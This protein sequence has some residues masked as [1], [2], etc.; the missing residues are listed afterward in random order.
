MAT[1]GIQVLL[2]DADL[3][4]PKQHEI[5]GLENEVGLSTLLI[6]NPDNKTRSESD[7]EKQVLTKLNQCIQLTSIPK[8][9]VITSGFVPSNPTEVLRSSLMK[10]WIDA[11]RAS[12]DIDVIIIDTPPLLLF[13]DSVILA[14]V[15]EA[16]A[17]L[18]LDSSHTRSRAAL[19]TRDQLKQV[20]IDIKGVILNRMNPRD[21]A[22]RYG[23]GYGYGYG[24]YYYSSGKNGDGTEKK[25]SLLPWR[26]Q[27]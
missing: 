1:D 23:Y 14:T 17:V 25:R 6:A 27:G 18:V 20:G 5:F 3:R 21:E 19:E 8:L 22:G 7:Q 9:K 26:R 11:F 24:Y 4:K 10:R 13:G 15:A 12:H 2:I 16:Y